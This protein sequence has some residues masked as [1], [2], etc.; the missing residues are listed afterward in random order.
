[1]SQAQMVSQIGFVG[2]VTVKPSTNDP[3][4][5][6]C[7]L[8]LYNLPERQIDPLADLLFRLWYFVLPKLLHGSGHDDERPMSS[9][10]CLCLS[11][12]IVSDAKF[13]SR[14]Q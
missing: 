3:H 13:P 12:D 4:S 7:G 11:G 2:I 1:M 6:I 10:K 14:S 9:H 5:T 8:S